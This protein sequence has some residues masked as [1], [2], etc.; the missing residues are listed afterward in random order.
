[1]PKV[2]RTQ[3]Q[4]KIVSG[5]GYCRKC[6]K[7]IP[8][9]N[10]YETTNKNLDSNGH[11]SICRLCCN[12]LYNDYF[13]IYNNLE[14]ALRLTC[15]ELDVCFNK[16]ALKQTQSHI[17][18]LLTR[19][20]KADAIFGYYKSKLSSTGKNNGNILDFRYKDSNISEID[21]D[22]TNFEDEKI[23]V[24]REILQF[25]GKGYNNQDYL[26]LQNYYDDLIKMYD[27]SLPVQVNNYKNMAKT[28]L[29]GNKS[30]ENGDITGYEKAMKILSM[31]SGDSNIKPNQESSV[32]NLTK[33]GYDVFIKH[34]EDDEP[35]LDWEKD[36][37]NIDRLKSMLNIYFFGHLSKALN[38][39]NP[40][41]SN[42]DEEMKK[43]TVQNINDEEDNT[44]SIDL[45]GDE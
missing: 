3:K 13:S 26:F 19:G 7:T 37:G 27:H 43:Y 6:Q 16:E 15:E 45:L 24:S 36:L 2:G 25:W 35:I 8:L 41:K 11:M 30:L 32:G 9:T 42:Y 5:D 22:E 40:W 21:S 33:G 14:I 44:Q 23:V 17:E 31:L 29:Q 28:Q 10:F 18:S 4:P 38:I 12:Q 39:I 20:K 1:M 34:I